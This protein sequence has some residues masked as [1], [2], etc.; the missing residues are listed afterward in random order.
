MVFEFDF[1]MT[2]F[3]CPKISGRN[4]LAIF[5]TL[6]MIH[7]MLILIVKSFLEEMIFYFTNLDYRRLIFGRTFLKMFLSSKWTWKQNIEMTS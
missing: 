7:R 2:L 4:I 1:M 3:L 6:K 5:L